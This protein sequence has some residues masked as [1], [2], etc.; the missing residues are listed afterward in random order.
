MGSIDTCDVNATCANTN[1]SFT[2]TC[3]EGYSGNGVNCSGEY[4]TTNVSRCL[5]LLASVLLV[6]IKFI[7]FK[8]SLRLHCLKRICNSR[9]LL[10][11]L[12]NRII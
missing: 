10:K 7:I 1:G 4:L 9:Y 12:K 5:S 11:V 6:I 8:Y 3:N 2:C